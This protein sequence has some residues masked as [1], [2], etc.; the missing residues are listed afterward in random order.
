VEVAPE[1]EDP[2]QSIAHNF[3]KKTTMLTAGHSPGR[4]QKQALDRAVSFSQCVAVTISG[5]TH[6]VLKVLPPP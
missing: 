5:R 4:L 1:C 3:W 6:S 2:V